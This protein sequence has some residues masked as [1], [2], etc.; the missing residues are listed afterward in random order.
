MNHNQRKPSYALVPVLR[1]PSICPGQEIEIDLFISGDGEV[2]AC[3]LTILHAHP[4]LLDLERD[5]P[6]KV[7]RGVMY[8]QEK[9]EVLR[10]QE[11]INDDDT[12]SGEF[13]TNITGTRIKIS[14]ELFDSGDDDGR[15]NPPLRELERTH[16][17]NGNDPPF[18]LYL[19]TDCNASPGDYEIT[20]V[21]TYAKDDRTFTA[22]ETVEPHIK[23]YREQNNKWIAYA[24]IGGSVIALISLIYSTGL[25]GF[26]FDRFTDAMRFYKELG[27]AVLTYS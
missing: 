26:L 6:G 24:I 27:D 4:N 1:T 21:L 9:E 3:H 10:G 16:P 14:S 25:F 18:R 7:Y 20:C 12:V 22:R 8:H 5:N 23:T 11:K 19:F 15:E 17:E 2:D 13:D